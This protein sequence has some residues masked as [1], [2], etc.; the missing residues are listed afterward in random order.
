[1]PTP[2]LIPAHHVHENA[3]WEGGNYELNMSFDTLRDKQWQR[4]MQSLWGHRLLYGPLAVRYVPGSDVISTPILVP[5]P[6]A[7]QAQHGQIEI[8]SMA[9]GCNVL[10]T[11]SLFE[12]V[13]V[14]VPLGMFAELARIGD[15]RS[16]NPQLAALDQVFYELALAVYDVV[17]FQLA[18][19]GWER[20]CQLVAEL[21]ADAKLRTQLIAAGNFFA[22]E[23][24]LRQ[25]GIAGESYSL[26]RPTLRFAPV[27]LGGASA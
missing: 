9:F 2:T 22:Q 1:V 13:S 24:G 7:T 15:M 12:C 19:V 6:T 26:T 17:P 25:M 21:R 11:R 16:A 3:Y 5:P 18:T 10:A 4:V 23:D 14:L 20:E 8:N 27:R